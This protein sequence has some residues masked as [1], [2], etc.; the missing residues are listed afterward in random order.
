MFGVFIQE[1]VG[2]H[3]K[4]FNIYKIR[5]YSKDGS[6]SKLGK[7]L[8]Q[9]KLNELLQLVNVIIGD[10]SLVGPRP[11]IRG[12][13]D[14]LEGDN[15]VILSIKPGITG[16]ATI[17]FIDEEA[18]LIEADNT[19]EMH[20]KIWKEKVRLNKDYIINYSLKKDALYLKKT[21]LLC[22]LKLK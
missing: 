3:A 13:A 10:M 7:F 1:R 9:S 17:K 22:L 18:L 5:T 19:K 14:A 16:P 11:D 15:K 21:L 4:P 8:R 20:N 6:S 2:Q 12:Y